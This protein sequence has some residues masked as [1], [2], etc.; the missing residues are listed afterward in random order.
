MRHNK[1]VRSSKTS[2]SFENHKN[3]RKINKKHFKLLNEIQKTVIFRKPC[4]IHFVVLQD[5]DLIYVLQLYN[6]SFMENLYY[7]QIVR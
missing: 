3:F 1:K 4:M 2:A 5:F 7:S 6:F